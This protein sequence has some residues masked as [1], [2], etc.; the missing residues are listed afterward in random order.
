MYGVAYTIAARTAA[1][2]RRPGLHRRQRHEGLP[3]RRLPARL[4]RPRTGPRAEYRR[5]QY[6]VV[7][8]PES[9]RRKAHMV[10]PPPPVKPAP[11]PTPSNSSNTRP[12]ASPSAPTWP[13]TAWSS[14]PIPSTPVG[15]RASITAP[16]RSTKSTARCAASP[17]P[18]APTPSPCA[19]APSA[20]IW[21]R[22]CPW[23]GILGALG[24]AA[25]ALPVLGRPFRQH[26]QEH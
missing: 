19:I 17:S 6:P 8:D 3:P 9:F 15:A 14:S 18:A 25:F 7:R 5:G 12:T 22:R 10:G 23:L 2:R 20:S 13:A 26:A 1:R 16:P 21:A 4:G 24:W 11:P